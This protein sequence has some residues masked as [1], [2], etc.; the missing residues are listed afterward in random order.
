[1]AITRIKNS[2]GML[3]CLVLL[4]TAGAVP[5]AAGASGLHWQPW[6]DQV[7]AQAKHEHKFVLLDL[8]AVW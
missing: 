2:P 3:F 5:D 1:M 7:F 8:E 6:S 4:L